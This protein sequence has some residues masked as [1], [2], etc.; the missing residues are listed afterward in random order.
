MLQHDTALPSTLSAAQAPRPTATQRLLARLRWISL[1][2][3]LAAG[4]DPS[5]SALLAAR[6]ARLTEPRH[7]ERLAAALGGLAPA[8]ASGP[9]TSRV[10]PDRSA[11]ARNEHA[12]RA[13][14]RL[15]DS[16]APVYARGLA[17]LE[18]LLGDSTGPVFQGG[19]EALGAELERVAAELRGAPAAPAG[20]PREGVRPR[21]GTVGRLARL[22]HSTAP[23]PR[24]DPP[25]FAGG[26]FA[27]PD[28]S[29]FHG[30]R[31]AS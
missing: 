31:E 7:R 18:R 30:R 29:W 21:G 15:V 11:L 28:G 3:R 9:H 1:D 14:A 6:A 22:R 19:G 2:D 13:L 27:L 20:A 17:R 4:E 5:R 10:T 24:V 8:A 26:S 25:G 12:V 23:A 16:D